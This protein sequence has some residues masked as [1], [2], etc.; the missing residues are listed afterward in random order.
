M[1]DRK[2]S[3]KVRDIESGVAIDRLLPYSSMLAL[4]LLGIHY[5][6]GDPKTASQD[7]I[8]IPLMGVPSSK[9]TEKYSRPTKKDVLKIEGDDRLIR[10]VKENSGYLALISQDITITEIRG[11]EISNKYNPEVPD[12]IENILNCP[13]HNCIAHEPKPQGSNDHYTPNFFV[14][15]REP[16]LILECSYCPTQLRNAQILKNFI[17]K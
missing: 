13:R 5:E 14:V 12:E 16:E 9:L 3:K 10:L 7:A 6:V 15:E 4:R 2:D 11:W 17:T 8:I 1:K